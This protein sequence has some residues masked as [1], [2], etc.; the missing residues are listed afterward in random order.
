MRRRSSKTR[1]GIAAA[2]ALGLLA[3]ALPGCN[4]VG[5]AYLL[6]HG[7]PKVKRLHQLDADAASIVFVDDINSQAPRRVLRGM[8]ARSAEKTLLEHRV[9]KNMIGGEAAVTL[10][11]QDKYGEPASIRELGEE[12]QADVVVYVSIDAFTL[13]PDGQTFSPTAVVRVKVF[14][15]RTEERTWPADPAGHPMTVRPRAK[16]G[17]VPEGVS[18]VTQAENE[19]ADEVGRAVAELFF[20]HESGPFRGVPE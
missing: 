15:V 16:Q 14:D 3:L 17:Y 5:P 6:I 19:L 12:L 8:I 13:T 7:P 11:S 1:P 20:D 2:G 10:A 4:I 9:L 18:G